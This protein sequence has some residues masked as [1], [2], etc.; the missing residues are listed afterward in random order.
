MPPEFPPEILDRITDF[1]HDTPTALKDLCLVSKSR[2]PRAQI[3]IFDHVNFKDLEDISK[4]KNV[5]QHPES[6]PAAMFTRSLSFHHITWTTFRDP[7]VVQS[8]TN[9]VQLG[10][11]INDTFMSTA[12]FRLFPQIPTIKSLGVGWQSI[13]LT[14]LVEF[15][16]LFPL[17]HDLHVDGHKTI[18][19]GDASINLSSLT[20]TLA[21]GAWG[22]DPI[23]QLLKPSDHLCFHKIVWKTGHDHGGPSA[24]DVIEWCSDTLEWIELGWRKSHVHLPAVTSCSVSD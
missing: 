13:K 20:G 7:F 12:S 2:V 23:H 8:F 24:N 1:L 15:L 11:W 21:I 5:F 18:I 10:I 17:L 19:D 22:A 6:S 16:G 4:W 3:H 14:Q 9:I